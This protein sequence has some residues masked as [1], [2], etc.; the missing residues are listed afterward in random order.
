M[1]PLQTVFFLSGAAGLASH[2]PKGAVL[3]AVVSEVFLGGAHSQIDNARRAGG[4]Q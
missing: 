3:V 2:R 4:G 1:R